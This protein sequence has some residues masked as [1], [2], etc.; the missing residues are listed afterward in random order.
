[1]LQ[2]DA[3]YEFVDLW[4]SY[5]GEDEAVAS[6]LE[7]LL[8]SEEGCQLRHFVESRKELT[9]EHHI[10]TEARLKIRVCKYKTEEHNPDS[11]S[12][13]YHLMAGDDVRNL[14]LDISKHFLRVVI[15]SESYFKK[16]VC[17]QELC[18]SLCSQHTKRNVYPLYISLLNDPITTLTTDRFE[19][20]IPS[21]AEQS[22]SP[23]QNGKK[24]TLA[25]ALK[26]THDFLRSEYGSIRGYDLTE[27][28]SEDFEKILKDYS[29]KTFIEFSDTMDQ[30]SIQS[31]IQSFVF[32]TCKQ[33]RNTEWQATLTD[34]FVEL[35]KKYPLSLL[36]NQQSSNN[37]A[38]S[39][40]N[41]ECLNTVDSVTE[42]LQ[43]IEGEVLKHRD[44]FCGVSVAKELLWELCSLV[45]LKAVRSVNAHFYPHLGAV[46]SMLPV[47]VES[48]QLG[49]HSELLAGFAYAIA[50]NQS[51]DLMEEF[52]PSAA[53]TASVKRIVRSKLPKASPND[54]DESELRQLVRYLLFA[55][56]PEL[57]A[58]MPANDVSLLESPD[59][60]EDL[61][62]AIDYSM[63]RNEIPAIA[64]RPEQQRDSKG[65]YS[66]LKKLDELLTASGQPSIG[67]PVIELKLTT[68]PQDGLE[69]MF[70]KTTYRKFKKSLQ[71][72]FKK[73]N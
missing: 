2:Q 26:E 72:V 58:E 68:K 25:G 9:T 66:V 54:T 15:L 55:I 18:M 62:E 31:A 12:F 32:K 71:S 23:D 46:N 17:M 57:I 60:I 69:V 67:L 33:I 20:A 11:N 29:N 8:S 39:S 59:F 4:F 63:T 52:N 70:T 40:S 21:N 41:F 1:M 19:F 61:R 44:K 7:N 56:D 16:L 3:K 64:V 51:V 65:Y 14:V 48:E 50:H 28:S 42:F 36:V 38:I 13:V 5:A 24:P 27:K 30:A 49:F 47:Y 45:I 34:R 6:Q 37:N 43:C 22:A 73:V 53:E 10:S 35:L